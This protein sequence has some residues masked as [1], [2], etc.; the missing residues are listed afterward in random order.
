M[1]FKLAQ[2]PLNPQRVYVLAVPRPD[3]PQAAR[4]RPGLYS[5]VD[6]GKA[7][8]LAAAASR[9]PVAS[10]FSIGAD[11]G[12]VGEVYVLLPPLGSRGVYMSTDAGQHWG[13]LPSLPTTDPSSI[14]GVRVLAD[15]VHPERLFLWSIASGLFESE[16]SGTT[17]M[18]APGVTG[19]IFAFS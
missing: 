19:G 12:S 17:W 14:R 3:N 7:W 13:A 5:S 1:L 18:P 2:S 11:A 6:A 4:A 8:T 10:I 15:P 9:F 16:D